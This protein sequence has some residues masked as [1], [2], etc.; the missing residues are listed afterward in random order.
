MVDVLG[1]LIADHEQHANA[2]RLSLHEPL[3]REDGAA[4]PALL[5]E[6]VVGGR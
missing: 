5:D 1:A 3:E 2:H 6:D 4:A